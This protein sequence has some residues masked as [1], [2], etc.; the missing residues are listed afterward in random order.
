MRV[1]LTRSEMQN[2]AFRQLLE[3]QFPM[4]NCIEVALLDQV[5][6]D[7]EGIVIE[8]LLNDMTINE[9]I[10]ISP[11]AVE[12]GAQKI[13]NELPMQHYFTV[14]KGTAMMLEACMEKSHSYAKLLYPRHSAGGEALLE[15]EELQQV[16]DKQFLI[17]T[18]AE[19]K[20]LLGAELRNRGAK[21]YYWECYQRRKPVDLNLQLLEAFKKPVD[22]VMLHSAHAAEYFLQEMPDRMDKNKIVLIVGAQS[23]ADV[24]RNDGWQGEVKVADTPIAKDMLSCMVECINLA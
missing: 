3:A 16:K 15:L 19:G 21:V 7:V 6:K 10:F 18:G 8:Q 14:G 5:P 12:F 1:L 20:P 11:A 2:A 4:L 23:I 9:V 13:L 17:I 22:F 24:I